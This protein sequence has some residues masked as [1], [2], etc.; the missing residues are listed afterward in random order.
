MIAQILVADDNPDLAALLEDF[1]TEKKHKVIV[2]TDGFQLAEK[3]AAHQPHLII[4][5]IQMPDIET[6]VAILRYKAER[7]N[8]F[9]PNDV[10]SYIARISK[11]R[12]WPLATPKSTRTSPCSRCMSTKIA[13]RFRRTHRTITPST[14]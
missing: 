10:V 5:D 7:K 8:V 3:A 12:F 11:R 13:R 14:S 4:A 9:L 2:A 6:R 1:L